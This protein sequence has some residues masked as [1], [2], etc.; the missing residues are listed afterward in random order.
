MATR[1]RKKKK[2]TVKKKDSIIEQKMPFG[3]YK[4]RKI[5]NLPVGYLEWMVDNFKESYPEL[6]TAAKQA[7]DNLSEFENIDLDKAADEFLE[8]HGYPELCI[9]K[10]Q[11]KKNAKL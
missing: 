1:K 10:G 9:T 3:K 4:G 6:V 2:K 7:I 8:K 5:K 11:R